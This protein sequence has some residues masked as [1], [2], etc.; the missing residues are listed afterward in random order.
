MHVPGD[1]GGSGNRT[2]GANEDKDVVGFLRSTHPSSDGQ[3][4]DRVNW[5]TG[6]RLLNW[7]VTQLLREI[8]ADD[9]GVVERYQRNIHRVAHMLQYTALPHALVMD[10]GDSDSLSC[11]ASPP[12]ST[13][14]PQTADAADVLLTLLFQNSK[15]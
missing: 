9:G 7:D 10:Q 1:K 15:Q 2:G 11:L 5:A 4:L 3:G 13:W 6:L 8:V 12:P 14:V